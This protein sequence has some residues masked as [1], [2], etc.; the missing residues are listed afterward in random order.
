MA[1]LAGGGVEDEEYDSDLDEYEQR[2]AKVCRPAR[3]FL[4]SIVRSHSK[5][6]VLALPHH[7]PCLSP[8]APQALAHLNLPTS[9]EF[10]II[11]VP[12]C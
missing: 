6:L 1:A 12:M 9:R 5:T 8:V 7:R 3:A 11:K 2:Q 10:R 4:E